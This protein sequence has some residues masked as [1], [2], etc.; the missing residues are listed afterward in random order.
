M[1]KEK[2]VGSSLCYCPTEDEY[3]FH[4][5]A[6]AS[7]SVCFVN[8]DFEKVTSRVSYARRYAIKATVEQTVY[9][10]KHGRM[11]KRSEALYDPQIKPCTTQPD[12]WEF[13]WTVHGMLYRMYYAEERGRNPEFVAL[14]FTQKTTEGLAADK[15]RVEQN[16]AIAEAQRRFDD[17]KVN[18]W[19]HL[20]PNCK[21]C[22]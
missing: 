16:E 19:G 8:D 2:T 10:A 13:R 17:Y 9:A 1:S 11:H 7:G 21:Y 12:I 18:Q 15:I 6:T 4:K 14:S 20:H 3:Q 5:C 22:E